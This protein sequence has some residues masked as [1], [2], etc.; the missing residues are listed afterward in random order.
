MV[1]RHSHITEFRDQTASLSL[2]L[3]AF[4]APKWKQPH[5]PETQGY[6][7]YQEALKTVRENYDLNPEN[8]TAPFAR[9][10]LLALLARLNL[11]QKRTTSAHF[12]SAIG[13]G[14]D[15]H[16]GIDAFIDII[17][18]GT[19]VKTITFD[20]TLNPQK[21]TTGHKADV[22]VGDLPEIGG[23]QWWRMID[24]ILTEVSF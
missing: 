11:S 16:H 10:L 19:I 3:D 9:D 24:G 6:L 7:P 2:E 8:P 23:E 14:L 1:E 20:A 15:H 5:S 17:K 22:I 18:S 12:Y 4:G 13:T 21:Q